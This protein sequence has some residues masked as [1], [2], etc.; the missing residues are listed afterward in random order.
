V[1]I[2]AFNGSMRGAKSITHLITGEFLR[3]AADA[4]ATV[5]NV[6]LVTKKIAH[7]RGCL[8]C[9][10]KT[11]GKCI[12]HDDMAPL[13][14]TFLASDIVVMASPVYIENVTG[15]MKDFMDRLIPITDPH[16]EPD[17]SGETRHV[18]KF[19]KYPGIFVISTCGFPESSAFQ[20]L[21]FLF[22][23]IARSLNAD[24]LGGIYRSG[25]GF[26]AVDEPAL[27]PIIDDYK[28]LV[29]TAG[30]EIATT[31][32]L[33]EETAEK[34]ERQLIPT[35]PYNAQVNLI[36]DHL[37]AKAREDRARNETSAAASG[38]ATGGAR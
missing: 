11:P 16:F 38:P 28:A 34:L 18:K 29:R 22:P 21:K 19:P 35:E 14:E 27:A 7:C 37:M 13:L 10:I 1:K 24:Y 3:G 2:T 23:R 8:T 17:E 4:G 20:V 15:L 5:D 9:W 31:M 25:G 36:W 6:F 32:T 26:L 12:H 30:A 33:S